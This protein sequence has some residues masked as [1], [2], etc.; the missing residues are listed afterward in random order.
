MPTNSTWPSGGWIA[1]RRRSGK[2]CRIRNLHDLFKVLEVENIILCAKLSATASRSAREPLGFLALS[3]LT[4]P[5]RDDENWLKHIMLK[6]GC[7][8][9]E[10]I[11]VSHRPLTKMK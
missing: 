6:I 10:E 11:L 7:S 3:V 9:P 2:R 4:F 8:D 5:R 1:S